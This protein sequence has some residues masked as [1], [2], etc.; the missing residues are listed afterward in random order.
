MSVV[1]PTLSDQLIAQLGAGRVIPF[2]GAG[3]SQP[4]G[5]PDWPG[6][7]HAL[8]AWAEQDGIP[9]A[10]PS[11]LREGIDGEDFE[12][13]AH[14]LDQALGKRL[15]E[16]L[17][18]ILA[19]S[20]PQ[21]TEVHNLLAKIEWPAV[22]TT[23]FDGLLPL[24]F[25]Q[26]PVLTWRDQEPIGRILRSGEPHL[27][28]A[29]GW[30]DKPETIVLTPG[31][32][33]DSFS[34]PA[35]RH[36]LESHLSQYSFLFVGFS[37]KDHDLNY[38]LTELRTAFGRPS[39]PHFALLPVDRASTL[40]QQHLRDNFGIETIPYT[41]THGH[42]EVPAFIKS[43][44]DHV[45]DGYLRDPSSRVEELT[46]LR[47]L[48]TTMSSGDYHE[49]F[50][51]TCVRLA[52]SGF[53]RTAA[54]ALSAELHQASNELSLPERINTT[55]AILDMKIVD[56]DVDHEYQGLEDLLRLVAKAAIAPELL[57]RFYE[58]VFRVYRLG[59]LLKDAHEVFTRAQGCA[60]N[61]PIVQRMAADLTIAGCLHDGQLAPGAETGTIYAL[62]AR[63]ELAAAE[64]QLEEGLAS[65]LAQRHHVP[66]ETAWLHS[67]RAE[68][69]FKDCAYETAREALDQIVLADLSVTD[70]IAYERNGAFLDLFLNRREPHQ[71]RATSSDQQPTDR[72]TLT[73]LHDRLSAESA[74][75]EQRHYLSL[76]PLWR[77]L[78]RSY[79][80]GEWGAVTRAHERLGRETLATGWVRETMHHAILGD[81]EA[82]A[83]QLAKALLQLQKPE[84]IQIVVDYVLQQCCLATHI[85]TAG[86]LLGE[87][88][89]VL[90]DPAIEPI[91]GW[92]TKA[93]NQPI[94]NRWHAQRLLPV[95][96][97]AQRLAF[98]LS[99]E[100]LRTF[101]NLARSHLAVP[102]QGWIRQAILQAMSTH[103]RSIEGP[104]DWEELATT[105]LPIATTNHWTPDYPD[106][107][108]LLEVI[109]RK[110]QTARDLIADT[111]LPK[112]KGSY[113]HRILELAA[114]LG[115]KIEP[116]SLSEH[117]RVIAQTLA[118]AVWTGTGT[119]PTINAM[120]FTSQ[121]GGEI[122]RIAMLTGSS[123]LDFIEAHKNHLPAN[124]WSQLFDTVLALIDHPLN[125]RANKIILAEFLESM[126]AQLTAEQTGRT[127]A[128]LRRYADNTALPSPHDL[129]A[130][131]TIDRFKINM[132]TAEQLQAV[133]IKA[134]TVI[135]KSEDD[136]GLLTSAFLHPDRALRQTACIASIEVMS[137]STDLC[138][139]LITAIQDSEG[140]VATAALHAANMLCKRGTLDEYVPLLVTLAERT[141]T[142]SHPRIR[143]AATLLASTL[144][145]RPTA[146]EFSDR[147]ETI[148]ARAL[149]DLHY[150]IR[151]IRSD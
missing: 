40:R 11:L 131:T 67:K 151:S 147:L 118:Q 7:L 25:P 114:T 1:T 80:A 70:R 51:A 41:P 62:G 104:Y 12:S 43:V 90:P 85:S 88:T 60:P 126:A 108:D 96:K 16:G 29:H 54:N 125:L 17:R 28:M 144:A 113:S 101:V 137:P 93:L 57:L 64:G 23:N 3:I 26:H 121:H 138:L 86:M 89:D 132:P 106:A 129:P 14:A 58:V 134:M 148:R 120:S 52:Q 2:L 123:E 143:H 97:A 63:S 111:L 15:L 124:E 92:I 39:I 105:V 100:Q 47:T 50:R 24:V 38:F 27:M 115:R 122:T 6:L 127:I 135:A 109:A 107:L 45:P 32:Y 4:A 82:L 130:P 53:L 81:S 36:Y 56:H 30:I 117:L 95:W 42:P 94:K 49:R 98:R 35:M 146:S 8:V 68:L 73:Q 5:L 33:R 139:L 112:G 133:A 66:Q 65:L 9:L 150:S 48:R 20:N 136:L 77:E 76:P 87:L 44:I 61:D 21:P 102:D 69:L 141:Q 75:S 71:P 13:V 78:L 34:E 99:Q 22:I 128:I 19:P 37:L 142:S 140:T 149:G 119:P 84:P 103:S 10:N 79:L 110:N 31:A 91:I 46:A 74:S 72:E 83:K 55:I 59:Y 145:K 18:C 116:E